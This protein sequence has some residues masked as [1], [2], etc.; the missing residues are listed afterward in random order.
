MKLFVREIF[1][2]TALAA[3]LLFTGCA[4]SSDD[5]LFSENPTAPDTGDSSAA[6]NSSST[7]ANV[8]HFHVGE[9]V[10][11]TFSGTADPIEPH[12]EP[13]KENGDIQLPLIGN[14]HAA[15]KSAGE[16]QNEIHDLYVPKYYVRLTVTVKPGDLIYYVT[17]EVKQPGR[18]IYIGETTVSKAVTSAGGFTDFA[19]HGKVW[20]IRVNGQRIKVNL[21]KVMGGSAPDPSVYPGDQ[22]EVTRRI[23]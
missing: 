4:S 21:D 6:N 2:V 12:D 8:A 13:I 17:G 22:I 19:N 1:S 14:I 18:E 5:P 10:S 23:W 9:T 7:Y 20:L 15:G 3:S 11:I 16:L